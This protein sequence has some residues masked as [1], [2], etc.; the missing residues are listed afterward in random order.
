MLLVYT[1]DDS[2]VHSVKE[3]TGGERS[4]LTMW[5]TLDPE[6]QEDRKVCVQTMVMP[7]I[8]PCLAGYRPAQAGVVCLCI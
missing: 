2:N 3:V 1:A 6:H 7:L 8:S 4:T 5:F